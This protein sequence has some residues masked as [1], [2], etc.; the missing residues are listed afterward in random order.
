MKN[1]IEQLT[2]A[3]KTCDPPLDPGFAGPANEEA[4]RRA[5]ATLNVQFGDDLKAF[6]LCANGQQNDGTWQTFATTFTGD[7]IVPGLRFGPASEHFSAWGWLLG[8]EGIVKYT[9][10]FRQIVEINHDE[11][12]ESHGPAGFHDRYILI[13]AADDPVSL[14]ID[15]QPRKGGIPGQIV[16][17]NDQPN[18]VAVIAPNLEAFLRT[19]A[20][21][22]RDGRFKLQQN[23]TWCEE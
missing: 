18:H 9:L 22:Y 10:A 15:L 14:G 21:G 3:L 19:V 7:P 5:E 12:Y 11:Q 13:S 4:L 1:I 6:L 2:V 23:G 20:D 16:T 8:V 17:I